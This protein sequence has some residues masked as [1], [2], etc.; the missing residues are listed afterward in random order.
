MN[1]THRLATLH[2]SSK[3]L[4][5]L[6]SLLN[7][8]GGQSR[9]EWVIGS[10]GDADGDAVLIDVDDPDGAAAWPGLE[11]RPRP[12][13]ALS[14]NRGFPA[15]H[16]LYKPIRS[17]Q[18]QQLLGDLAAAD[19]APAG[20]AGWPALVFEQGDDPALPLAEHLRRRSWDQPVLLADASDT[21]LVIDPGAG[22]W[23]SNASDREFDALFHRRI[24]RGE[25]RSL[26]STEL[27]D[28]T[29][30]LEQQRL[31]NLKW[32]AGLALSG[33]ALH[34]E[35]VGDVRFML[36]QVPLQALSDTAYS[37]QARALLE[38]PKDVAELADSSHADAHDVAAFLNAC[39]VC[40]FLV[41][42]RE[43]TG[44]AIEG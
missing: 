27:I 35:L 1:A 5:V 15:R 12:A 31:T 43:T 16:V 13:V 29:N 28:H 20:G 37:R 40:G 3:D 22:V 2:V 4:K 23:Y 6:H 30:G 10:D 9:S 18:L 32:R 41:L 38:R 24:R 7:L 19:E 11:D 26:S 25:V 44:L 17:Q 42:D 36:P 8:T 39:H 14:R 34:P 21:W 33:R